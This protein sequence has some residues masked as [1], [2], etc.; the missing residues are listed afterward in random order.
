MTATRNLSD[1]LAVLEVMVEMLA[2]HDMMG[3]PDPDQALAD[4]GGVAAAMLSQRYTDDELDGPLAALDERVVK[5]RQNIEI[6][7]QQL[8]KERH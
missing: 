8:A 7:R 3:Q 4:Y 5:I 2:A 6:F 1:R